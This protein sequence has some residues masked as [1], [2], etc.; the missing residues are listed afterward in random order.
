MNLGSSYHSSLRT[1][2]ARSITR[3]KM[4]LRKVRRLEYACWQPSAA[5]AQ[6]RRA[7]GVAG[8]TNELARM[9]TQ[10]VYT[11]TFLLLETIRTVRSTYA[12]IFGWGTERFMVLIVLYHPLDIENNNQHRLLPDLACWLLRTISLRWQ[13][14]IL[15]SPGASD[16]FHLVRLCFITNI[17]YPSHLIILFFGDRIPNYFECDRYTHSQWSD[18]IQNNLV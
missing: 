10:R 17:P 5:Q 7:A 12:L 4:W 15:G 3:V 14:S 18:R 8:H 13:P 11:C 16:L 6:W 2:I 1:N 9:F